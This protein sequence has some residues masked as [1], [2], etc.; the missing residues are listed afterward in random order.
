MTKVEKGSMISLMRHGWDSPKLCGWDSLE[1]LIPYPK[2]W[3]VCSLRIAAARPCDG[4][5]ASA[6]GKLA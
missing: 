5:Q 2:A 3:M 1:S 4:K 6:N